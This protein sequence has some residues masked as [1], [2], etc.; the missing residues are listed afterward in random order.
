MGSLQRVAFIGAGNL[1]WNLVGGLLEKGILDAGA[2]V[3]GNR[4]DDPRLERFSSLGIAT[5]RDKVLLLEGTA[6]VVLATKPH[7]AGQALREAA[8]YVR[9]GALFISTVAGLPLRYL[10]MTL[11]PG[12][13]LVRAMPNTSCQVGQSATALAPAQGVPGEL[14]ARACQLFRAVG[15]V[16]QVE[17]HMLDAITAV[18]GSG[19]A[20]FYFF[21]ESLIR[22][23][24]E[25]GLDDRLARDLTIQTLQ[26]AAA[27][28]RRPGTDPSQLRAQVTSAR[29]TTEAALEV[30]ARL[31][32][33]H[34]VA[35]GV[36]SAKRRSRELE[37]AFF[38]AGAVDGRLAPKP[39]SW[40]APSYRLPGSWK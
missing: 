35:E 34:A 28:L 37:E 33:P 29:G 1:A 27:M 13:S 32:L 26:G 3:V 38:H 23:G 5:T 39:P 36:R 12:V 14:I 19:P 31:K 25:A 20:Y 10:S 18:S 2:V 9:R 40:Q 30:M 4:A 16:Y 24:V 15:E 8:P 7:D 6:T 11:G 22:A 21:I 17:E